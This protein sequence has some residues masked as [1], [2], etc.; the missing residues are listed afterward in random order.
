MMWKVIQASVAG[1]SHVRTG[2]PCQDYCDYRRVVVG[3][4]LYVVAACADGA[5]S[6]SFSEYGALI[7]VDTVLSEALAHL[8]ATGLAAIGRDDVL[9]W[10]ESAL[11]ELRREAQ[12]LALADRELACTLLLAVIGPSRSV[13]AQ[14]G[15]G[16]IVRLARISHQI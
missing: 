9:G 6:A 3:D 4:E 15:D 12:M 8:T 7:A 16:A 5:G 2:K 1:T 13:F 14:I 11:R 10:Y